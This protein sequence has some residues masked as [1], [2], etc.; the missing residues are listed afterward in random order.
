LQNYVVQFLCENGEQKD[1]AAVVD[2]L[3]GQLLSM[4]KH[5]FASNVVEKVLI[6]ADS[7]SRELL[8]DEILLA[9]ED[10][11]DNIALMM[12]DQYA[13]YVLQRAMLHAEG[14]QQIDLCNRLRPQL[15][16]MR[17]LSSVYTK[18]LNSIER[19]LNKIQRA[20][21]LPTSPTSTN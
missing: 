4:S 1:R 18:H 12:K 21:G 19:C 10:G 13:N 5:K 2:K 17:K 15:L 11:Q 6:T 8:I 7:A 20:H 9:G 14:Q 16:A 3:R